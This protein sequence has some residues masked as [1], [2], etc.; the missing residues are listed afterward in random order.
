MDETTVVSGHH[1]RAAL[2]LWQYVEDSVAWIFGDKLGDH[3][4]DTI[5]DE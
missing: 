4:A 2:A 5:L 1:M 3:I